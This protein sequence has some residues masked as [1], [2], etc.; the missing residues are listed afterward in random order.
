M[1]MCMLVIVAP[2]I[3]I[4]VW[5][6]AFLLGQHVEYYVIHKPCTIGTCIYIIILGSPALSSI[7]VSPKECNYEC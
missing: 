6:V 5:S 7:F 2:P 3:V 4:V 1:V